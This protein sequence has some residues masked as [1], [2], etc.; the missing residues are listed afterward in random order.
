M[1]QLTQIVKCLLGVGILIFGVLLLFQV[2]SVQDRLLE[3]AIQN[4]TQNNIP[5]EDSLTAI[6]CG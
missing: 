1:F 6:V 5:K 3:N 2:P 4:L